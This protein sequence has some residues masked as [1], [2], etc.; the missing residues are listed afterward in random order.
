[1]S[2]GLRTETQTPA[3]GRQQPSQ[4]CVPRRQEM[5]CPHG[6][7]PTE[8]RDS[9]RFFLSSVILRL[10]GASKTPVPKPLPKPI[11]SESMRTGDQL[12]VVFKAPQEIP[13]CTQGGEL[14]FWMVP[15]AS[16]TSSPVA[17]NS[18]RTWPFPFPASMPWRAKWAN[19]FSPH[20]RWHPWGSWKNSPTKKT[21]TWKMNI[22]CSESKIPLGERDG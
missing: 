21:E 22:P 16:I 15:E 4:V 10:W 1:M 3:F 5:L 6:L 14:L 9:E 18:L 7:L 2:W 17:K 8:A 12:Q 13:I 20:L 11:S 19:R